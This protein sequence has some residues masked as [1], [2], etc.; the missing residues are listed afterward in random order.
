MKNHLYRDRSADVR[1]PFF[2]GHGR[3]T[4]KCEGCDDDSVTTT[5]YRSPAALA[6]KLHDFCCGRY[7]YCYHY[8]T[9]LYAKYGGDE[10]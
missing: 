8:R 5:A 4:L 6:G 2:L 3:M 10:L 1:C 7:D 9:V